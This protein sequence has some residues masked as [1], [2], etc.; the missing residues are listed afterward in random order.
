MKTPTP[1]LLA[2]AALCV[3]EASAAPRAHGSPAAPWLGSLAAPLLPAEDVDLMRLANVKYK[4][5]RALPA[6]ITA[7]DGKQIRIEGYMSQDTA[8]GVTTFLLTY[9]ACSCSGQK[10]QHFVEVTLTEEL[11]KFTPGKVTVTGKL[12]VGEVEDEFGIVTSIYR[13]EAEKYEE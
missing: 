10:V 11:V 4:Q 9:D 6:D 5:G 12:S 2:L 8:E 7:L 1:L 3:P 13:L